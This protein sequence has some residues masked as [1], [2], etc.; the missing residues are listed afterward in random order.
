VRPG[1]P[2]KPV[3]VTA[4]QPSGAQATGDKT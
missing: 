1:N 3:P 4:P 2:V